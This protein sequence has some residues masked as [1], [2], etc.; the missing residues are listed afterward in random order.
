MFVATIAEKWTVANILCAFIEE[1]PRTFL[2]IRGGGAK[3]DIPA[4]V[5]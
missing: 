5:K 2:F 1:N 3:R 4:V